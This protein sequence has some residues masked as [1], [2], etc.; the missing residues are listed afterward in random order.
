MIQFSFLYTQSFGSKSQSHFYRFSFDRRCNFVHISTL[1]SN[2]KI[3]HFANFLE[4]NI[5]PKLGC[6]LEFDHFEKDYW[7]IQIWCTVFTISKLVANIIVRDSQF[8]LV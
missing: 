1:F 6:K 5:L 4:T 3:T 8:S 7:T 2:A